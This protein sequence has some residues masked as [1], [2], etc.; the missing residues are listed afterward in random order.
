MAI[1]KPDT[2]D[3]ESGPVKRPANA[4]RVPNTFM[5]VWATHTSIH[6]AAACGYLIRSGSEVREP[7]RLSEAW[8]AYCREHQLPFILVDIRPK[9]G[10]SVSLETVG[11]SERIRWK[12]AIRAAFLVHGQDAV[13]RSHMDQPSMECNPDEGMWDV[14]NVSFFRARDVAEA[15]MQYAGWSY[16]SP[17]RKRLF[18]GN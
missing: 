12:H 15:V 1:M 8:Y 3:T 11:D 13:D 14:R 9:P 4:P 10:I 7:G 6:D 2:I 18:R 5:D 16:I 17:A